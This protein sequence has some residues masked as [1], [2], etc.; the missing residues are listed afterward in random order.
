[1]RPVRALMLMLCLAAAATVRAAD[2][3]PLFTLHEVGHGVWAATSAPTSK[4]GSNA[5]FVIGND[6][7][8]VVDSFEDPAA[9]RALLA[10]IHART[11]LPVRY[12]VNTHYHLDHVAGNGVFRDAG[13]VILA[14]HSVRA[15]ERT[16]NLKFF[17][18]GITP[19]Q[20]AMVQAYVL[21]TVTY[22]DGVDIDLGGRTVLVQVMPG[23]TGGDSV[24]MVPDARVVFT[25]DLFWNHSLP[26]LID[27]D[28]AAQ[29]RTNDAFLR[30]HPDATFVPG[31]GEVAHAAD[32]RAFRDYLVTLRQTITA[33]QARGEHGDALQRDV[34]ARLKRD[35][36]HWDYFGYFAASNITQTVAELAGHKRRPVPVP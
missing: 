25:G 2:A 34:L 16:E 6:A 26:N 21:P 32:V 5:G 27:A 24:V 22:R 9:A 11:S 7:V 4:A 18:P 36:G 17:G 29:I 30:E 23:H 19:A 28:T 35:C 8:L 10:A 20:K 1:M 33:A 31:H 13:A 12:L 15:W 3:P 14:Q